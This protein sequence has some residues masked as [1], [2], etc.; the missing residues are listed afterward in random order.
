MFEY[1]FSAGLNVW[2]RLEDV[3]LLE[4]ICYS[5]VDL[6]LKPSLY[7]Q[8]YLPLD[9]GIWTLRCSAGYLLTLLH[10]VIMDPNF[11]KRNPIKCFLW[12]IALTVVFYHSNRKHTKSLFMN[13]IFCLRW[14]N[15]ILHSHTFEWKWTY[16]KKICLEITLAYWDLR[17]Q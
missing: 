6:R 10:Y 13:M 1:W 3:A 12:Y 15:K 5:L 16:L 9:C 7:S 11:E 4:N 2:E 14:L 8:C 17:N